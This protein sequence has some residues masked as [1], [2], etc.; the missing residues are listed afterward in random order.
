[1]NVHSFEG[2][3][4]AA[5]IAEDKAGIEQLIVVAKRTYAID[6]S[7]K[8]SKAR[9]PVGL[10]FADEH[11]GD[12]A[13]S[14]VRYENDFA[15]FKPM[16][17]VIVNGSA[18][19]P[20]GRPT[21]AMTVQLQFGKLVRRARVVGD[22]VWRSRWILPPAP[23]G[24]KP[25]TR[26]PIVWERAF[27]GSDTRPKN[28]KRHVFETRNLLGVGLRAGVAGA[29][30][31]GSPLPNIEAQDAPVQSWKKSYTPVG[32]GFVPRGSEWRTRHA[33]TYD[34]QWIDERCPFLPDDFDERYYQGAPPEQIVPTPVG[35]ERVR[36]TGFT[37]E[38]T[39]EF[40]LP[41]AQGPPMRV[42]LPS[43]YSELAARLDTI[44]IEPDERRVIFTWRARAPLPCKPTDVGII[45]VGVPTRGWERSQR[46]VKSY[47]DWKRFLPPVE[48]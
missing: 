4:A 32:F 10:C 36:L 3:P 46:A 33:G 26:M 1:M 39:L 12:P 41:E 14:S 42:R 9:D 29:G 11:H 37:P 5:I 47:V 22:R 24:P 48:V 43:G 21:S 44:V 16:C 2:D 34:Q 18:C 8:T 30:P 6:S 7:G 15:P 40:R 17:D 19:A 31:V 28:P 25:F 20:G 27:G 23:S 35:G 45:L 13:S 38:G